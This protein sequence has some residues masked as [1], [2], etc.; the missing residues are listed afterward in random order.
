[1][2]A[3]VGGF[4]GQRAGG[5]GGS[6][7]LRGGSH[8]L[9][10]TLAAA[11][12]CACGPPPVEARAVWIDSS[13]SE[14]ERRLQIYDRGELRSLTV[15]GAPEPINRMRLGPRGRGVLV[16]SLDRRSVWIDLGDHRR[17]PL[18]LPQAEVASSPPVAFSGAG[19]ALHWIDDDPV[20]PGLALI[21]LAPGLALERGP[22]GIVPLRAG[23]S[24]DWRISAGTAPLVLAASVG[25]GRATLLRFPERPEQ[26]LALVEDLVVEGLELP[27]KPE[28]LTRCNAVSDCYSLASMDAAGEL[29][30]FAPGLDGPWQQVDRRAPARSGPIE[31][32]AELASAQAGGGLGLLHV[33][34]RE[35]SVWVGAGILYRWDRRAGEVE[36]FPVIAPEVASLG[37]SS[38]HWFVVDGG[39]A[40]LLVSMAGP[41]FRVDGEGVA[42]VSLET[43]ECLPASDPVVSPAGDWV[44]WTCFEVGANFDAA[45]GV[46]VRVS[47]RG[48]LERLVGVPMSVAAIDD[49][50]DLL[51]YSVQTVFDDQLDGVEAQDVP[52]SLFVLSG[53]GV[54]TQVDELEPA[55]AAVLVDPTKQQS[56]FIQAAALDAAAQ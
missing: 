20:D 25:A 40:V 39:R 10:L 30:V 1:M 44:A 21:P 15:L 48:G 24:F 3:F 7:R 53:D 32:P 29:A 5:G 11:L 16:R 12:T 56:T 41:V 18:L 19:T 51:L 23:G 52:R 42:P 27:S 31:F 26:P 22:S 36:S 38:L 35:L 33:I 37:G 47:A 50:G 34:D 54:L 4:S 2:G 17:L 9:A 28:L 45:E 6:P 13:S 46:V 55:P 49:G 8:G 14:G 43:T